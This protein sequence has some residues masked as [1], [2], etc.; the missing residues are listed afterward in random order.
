MDCTEEYKKIQSVINSKPK[1][2]TKE[3]ARKILLE[4]GV[5]DED[6]NITQPFKGIIKKKS[7]K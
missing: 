2:Y 5:I 7:S 4:F 3:E 6:D 1:K